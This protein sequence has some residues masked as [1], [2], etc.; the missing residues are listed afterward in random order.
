MKFAAKQ[1]TDFEIV[2]TGNHVAICNAVIDLGMQ[3]GSVQYP[4]PKRKVYLRFELPDE[5]T[6][7]T[8]DGKEVEG[9]MS[10]GTTFTASMNEKANLRHFVESWFGKKFP[11]D[12]AAEAFDFA[13]VIGRA[14]LLNV[15]HTEKGGKTYANIGN[16]T[17][18]LKGMTPSRPQHNPPLYFSL[19]EPDEKTFAALPKW[20]QEKIQTRLPEPETLPSSPQKATDDEFND[21]IPF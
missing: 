13:A 14:C 7:Y 4:S 19:D 3:P 8:K 2:P 9:P 18:M 16:A 5:R 1:T 10:I 21:D 6:T 11:N 15:T 20:L 17:P 12:G